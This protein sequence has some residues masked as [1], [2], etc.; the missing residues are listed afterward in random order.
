MRKRSKTQYLILMIASLSLIVLASA[1]SLS[2]SQPTPAPDPT[3]TLSE[4]AEPTTDT[5]GQNGVLVTVDVNGVAQSFSSQVVAAALQG[6]TR[7]WW[8]VLPEHIVL[9]LEG[10]P[11]SEHLIQPQIFIYPVQELSVN[12]QAGNIAADLGKLLQ[13]QQPGQNLPFLP[14]YN[15]GQ[16]MHAQTR[17]MDFQSGSGVRYLTQFDQAVN[18]INNGELIYTYQGL[19]SDGRFYVA[20]VLPVKLPGL[21]ADAN[22]TDTL[23]PEFFSNFPQYL[24]NMVTTLNQSDSS[25]FSPDLSALDA[26]VQ[27]IQVQ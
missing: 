20:V 26:L 21:P 18:P 4:A 5:S 3:A 23:P 12:E 6:P 10:Y 22:V 9:T 2:A 8:E 11:E 7:P 13:N 27:S 14:P 1:C 15:A 25:I 19:T 24:A 17:F 16:V